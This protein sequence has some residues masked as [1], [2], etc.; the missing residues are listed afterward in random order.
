MWYAVVLFHWLPANDRIGGC[1]PERMVKLLQ[2]EMHQRRIQAPIGQ[3]VDRAVL[4]FRWTSRS[5]RSA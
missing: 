2:S 5:K 4:F 1:S 3:Y